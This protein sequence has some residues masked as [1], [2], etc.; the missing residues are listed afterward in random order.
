MEVDLTD[1]FATVCAAVIGAGIAVV[2]LVISKE[3]NISEFRQ[4]WIDGL[5]ADV[6]SLIATAAAMQV[7]PLTAETYRDLHF[8][9]Q[10]FRCRV[11]LRFKKNDPGAVEIR[12]SINNLFQSAENMELSRRTYHDIKCLTEVTQTILKLEW[13]RVKAGEKNYQRTLK[14][15]KV[16]MLGLCTILSIW[17]LLNFVLVPLATWLPS[18]FKG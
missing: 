3:S 7:R 14:I 10:E 8:R 4:Q 16:A 6:S 5:R 18:L 17:I 2:G 9:L 11:E 12:E 15:S 1:G 13:E